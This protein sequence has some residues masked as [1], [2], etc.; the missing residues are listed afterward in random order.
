MAKHAQVGNRIY[1][2]PEGVS[3]ETAIAEK[4][5]KFV[6]RAKENLPAMLFVQLWETADDFD[7]FCELV[8]EGAGDYYFTPSSAKQ[9]ASKYRAKGVD[10]KKYPPKDRGIPELDYDK[11]KAEIAKIRAKQK[12]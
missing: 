9:R 11:L 10:L 8:R 12:K 4:T 1:L 7:G 6:R 2:I 3:T 5:A